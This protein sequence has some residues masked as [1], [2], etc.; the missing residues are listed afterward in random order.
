M[1]VTTGTTQEILSDI[2][3]LMTVQAELRQ[4]RTKYG[5]LLGPWSDQRL[6]RR[7]RTQNQ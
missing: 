2:V 4:C 6:R 5:N 3:S 1:S 7:S